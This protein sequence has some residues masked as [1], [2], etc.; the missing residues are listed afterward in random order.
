MQRRAVG[1]N[2]YLERTKPTIPRGTPNRSMRSNALGRAA[3]LFEVAKAIVN[4]SRTAPER[5]QGH[6]GDPDDRPE[7]EDSR[8]EREVGS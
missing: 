2:M 8:G 5:L 4:G 6:L 3:S 1:L 7:D